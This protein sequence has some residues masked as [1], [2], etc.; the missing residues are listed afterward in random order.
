MGENSD[1]SNAKPA[2]GKRT[3][4]ASKT[5]GAKP[6]AAKAQGANKPATGNG[7]PDNPV[8]V[9]VGA[10]AGG[11]D[12]LKALLKGF[13][14]NNDVCLVI[15]QHMSPSRDSLLKEILSQKT[16]FQIEFLE[17]PKEPAG[18]VMFIVPP[19][20]D[21][22]FDHGQLCPMETSQGGVGPRPSINRL[23][24]SMAA[25]LGNRCIGIVLSG[26]GSDGAKGLRAICD[27]GG[28]GLVQEVDTAQYAGMPQAAIDAGGAEAVLAPEAMGAMVGEL[29]S[30]SGAVEHPVQDV[31]IPDDVIARISATMRRA[32]RIDLDLYK[33]STV[34][35][36]LDKRMRALKL[37]SIEEYAAALESDSGES[38]K[39]A[40]ELSIGVTSFFRDTSAFVGL[41]RQLETLIRQL[42]TNQQLRCWVPACAS[43]EEA[44]TL[45]FLL[46]DIYDKAPTLA[47]WTVFAS[48]LNQESVNYAR[49]GSYPLEG[50]NHIPK[51]Y[52]DKYLDI[53]ETHFTIKKSLRQSMIFAQHDVLNDP[54]FS[55]LHCITCRNMLI[56][57]RPTAQRH[58]LSMLHYALV[59]TGR[60]MLGQAESPDSY[61]ELFEPVDQRSRIYE[62]TERTAVVNFPKQSKAAR[63]AIGQPISSEDTPTPTRRDVEQRTRNALASHFAPPTVV[64]DESDR[65]VHFAGD[66][67]PFVNLPRGPAD[68]LAADL[69][70]TPMN[71]EVRT[72]LHRARRDSGT[73][74]GD[75][76]TFEIGGKTVQVRP[77]AFLDKLSGSNLVML[78]FETLEVQEPLID[79]ST[80]KPAL[81]NTFVEEL[82]HELSDTREHL[83]SVIE[84]VESSN[85]ELQ[86]LNE[87]LQSSNEELQ[88]TNEE[89]QTSNEELQSTNEELTT[90]NQ[91]LAAKT[92]E[93][94]VS[95]ADL[96]NVKDSLD[97]A[98]LVVD[99][100]LVVTQFNRKLLELLDPKSLF[101]GSNLANLRWH[102]DFG[103]VLEDCSQVLQQGQPRS[104]II[105]TLGGAHF[106]VNL[107][108][109]RV[110]NTVN[111]VVMRIEDVTEDKQ[112]EALL[113]QREALYRVML[114][115]SAS[116]MALVDTNDNILEANPALS[117][118]IDRPAKDLLN[119]RISRYVHPED[120]KLLDAA[121]HSLRQQDQE[122]SQIEV[123][124]LHSERQWL[125]VNISA[126]MILGE[127]GTSGDV[128]MQIQDV[129][130][131]RYRQQKLIDEYAQLRVINGIMRRI[132][133]RTPKEELFAAILNDLSIIFGD[134]GLSILTRINRDE[135][136]ISHENL[137]D[138]WRSQ[139]GQHANFSEGP[140]YLRQ[141]QRD[142]LVAVEHIEHDELPVSL[143]RDMSKRGTE[144]W[145]DVAAFHDDQVLHVLRVESRET[146]RWSESDRDLL[147]GIADVLSVAERDFEATERSEK[148]I[149]AL[150]EH[151]R[152]SEAT[153]E[154]LSDAVFTTD[155]NGRIEFLN[156]A[157]SQL[158]QTERAQATGQAL[159]K[160]LEI[161]DEEQDSPIAN[162]VEL[163]IRKGKRIQLPGKPRIQL[164]HQ[165]TPVDVSA[166]PLTDSEDQVIGAVVVIR[167]HNAT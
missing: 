130:A 107:A 157:A 51:V 98:L 121:L 9:G 116:G 66:L 2:K 70:R 158:C 141:L 128:V 52:Q 1:S 45:A 89:L 118:L 10:S 124:L 82:Q 22:V 16:A 23:F 80:G 29:V 111:G 145:I 167:A 102:G 41:R 69:V 54:P 113:R 63:R 58:V 147:Q 19:G 136:A 151:S 76:Y 12:A 152:R 126:A 90:V 164:N 93:L 133:T 135:Y 160:L 62:R 48:D 154:H 161:L 95:R 68:W 49:V 15:A 115:S 39:L 44:Y 134:S 163:C 30:G 105:S 148:A 42:P 50:L 88:S 81:N 110:R 112:N 35:R 32:G 114:E 103:G 142:H 3:G 33:R 117:Q 122:H 139:R 106:R 150:S 5:H 156:E 91:E 108:P 21:A 100:N 146:R 13:P 132:S 125:W 46:A 123:R 119:A 61:R 129:S 47:G 127:S 59:P 143:Q 43:G 56:Y 84:E 17:E 28:V 67:A 6:D 64:I 24:Q 92:L 97:V 60:L 78:S 155:S 73:I 75:K 138:G 101:E 72:I 71:V 65:I 77:C 166:S 27:A 83:Q 99:A 131:R 74:H 153:L 14:R 37:R 18:G 137:P 104:R 7:K 86:T 159:F 8:V 55:K 26:T 162:P 38:A 31:D 11:L 34:L 79:E 120:R 94:E 4:K 20:S 149:R 165:W 85:E 109:Y 140:R 57:L 144:A 25:T 36:R 87:E 96:L 53:E 40:S